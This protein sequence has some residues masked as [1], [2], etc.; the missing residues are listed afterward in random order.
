MKRLIK[1]L[2]GL[3]VVVA[4]FGIIGFF[5]LPPII[6]PILVDKLSKAIQR[7]V[8]IDS[9]RINPYALSV[10][11][12]GFAVKERGQPSNF[13]SFDELY[14][15]A[16]GLSSI[17]KKA[18]ILK[19]IRLT[20]PYIS[21]SRN[22][23]GTYNF[24]D[25]IPKEEKKEE[26]KPFLF[27]LNNIQV[28]D[29]SVDFDDRPMKA[30]HTVRE[31]N[32][33]IPFVSDIGHYVE[34]YVEPRFSAKI[35]G[36][37]YELVGKTKPFIDSR[38]TSFELDIRDVDIPFYLNYIPVKL[39][40][41]LTSARL[42]LKMN[43][44]FI[45]HKDKPPSVKLAGDIALTKIALDDRQNKKILRV[46]ALKVSLASVEPLV[47]DIHLSR[48]FV[49]K[50]EVAVVRDREGEI[51]LL[52]LLAKETKKKPEKKESR[53]SKQGKKTALKA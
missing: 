32:L 14:V 44:N 18:V 1:I 25:L 22:D 53:E 4:L 45:M 33:S 30:H 35:N 24:S 17:F 10:S 46:P 6:K 26:G 7:E 42:D 52:N 20:R 2:V 28:L 43:I 38:E 34:D 5:V 50:P 39:N 47:P 19:E 37:P 31:L 3:I 23:D 49:E 40:C 12:K 51:N 8:A 27:S 16:Q 48:I 15:N 29:G 41:K 21:V 36:N 9:I 13:L 11:I